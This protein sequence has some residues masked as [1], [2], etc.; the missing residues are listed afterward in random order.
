MDT[1]IQDIVAAIRS[2]QMPDTVWLAK[3]IRKH[4]REVRA[5]E[6][7][8]GKLELLTY[9]RAV[10]DEAGEAWRSW[11]ISPE[12]DRQILRVLKL[13]PRRTASGVATITVVTMPHAC[14]SAESCPRAPTPASTQ[15]SA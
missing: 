1:I 4:N 14:S 7:H 15:P 9:Y 6:R 13:K 5:M 12:E 10:R 8:I 3:R 2:G 11:G